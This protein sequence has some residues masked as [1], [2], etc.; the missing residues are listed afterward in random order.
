MVFKKTQYIIILAVSAVL[1]FFQN[2]AVDQTS[3]KTNL[4]SNN[5]NSDCLSNVVDCGPKPEFLE[6]TIDMSNPYVFAASETSFYVYGR[7]NS[8]NYDEHSI[9]LT[10]ICSGDSV[11]R[12][13][14][15]YADLCVNGRYLKLIDIAVYPVNRACS[16]TAQILGIGANGAR[17]QNLQSGGTV[18]VDFSKQ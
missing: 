4:P 3:D 14:Q 8:G 6:I 2:C 9:R 1:L 13:N 17:V 11:N 18:T 7:C 15:E 12:L 10:T 5:N 16:I